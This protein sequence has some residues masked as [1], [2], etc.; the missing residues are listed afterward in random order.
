MTEPSG[1]G[2][3]NAAEEGELVGGMVFR[4][5]AEAFA[6]AWAIVWVC[7]VEV[8]WRST[9]RS[10]W[11]HWV[12]G[13]VAGVEADGVAVPDIDGSVAEG[14]AGAGVEDCD[15]EFEG[16]ALPVF[17]DVRAEQFVGD[18][19]GTDL[20]LG[21]ELTD[22]GVLQKA[23]GEGCALQFKGCREGKG[24]GEE[25]A[26]TVWGW[27]LH[28]PRGADGRLTGVDAVFGDARTRAEEFVRATRC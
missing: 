22:V 15:A 12:L 13:G 18:V 25:G 28:V 24:I 4:R 27:I 23:Q 19:V 9:R 20:L 8:W 26:A 5:W 21:C 10:S 11:T 6:R 17:N 16:D 2:D 14:F 7:W 1:R 3:L